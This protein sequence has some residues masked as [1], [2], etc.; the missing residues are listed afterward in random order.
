VKLAIKKLTCTQLKCL[1]TLLMCWLS[2][3]RGSVSHLRLLTT[4]RSTLL[5]T[6]LK[7][8]IWNNIRLV[9]SCERRVIQR[10]TSIPMLLRTYLILIKTNISIGLLV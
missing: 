1:Q 9:K 10:I 7:F 5:S 3:F 6:S 8:L 4:S 2:T